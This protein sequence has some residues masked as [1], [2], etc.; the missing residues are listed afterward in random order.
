[1]NMSLKQ[2]IQNKEVTIGSWITIGDASVAEIMLKADFDWLTIDME[3]SAITLAEAQQLIRVIDL[4]GKTPLVR[5]S[6]NDPNVIKRVMDAGAHGVIV[7]MVNSKEEALAAVNAVQ[8]PP[9]GMRGVGLGRAQGYGVDFE[10]YQKWV[11]SES[12][13]IIQVEHIRAVESLET[14]LSVKGVDGFMVGPYDLSAS[15]GVPGEFNHPEMIKALE[16]IKTVS[17]KFNVASGIHVI[18]PEPE[19]VLTKI[20]EG[21]KFI[22][23]SLDSLFLAETCRRNLGSV[24]KH[25]TQ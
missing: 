16:R 23:F 20:K 2:K 4:G 15:L 22:A 10:K 14:I 5:V 7:P 3:H 6:H 12:V 1:M 24:R 8:Y 21:F 11:R 19:L 17:Q 25:I 13:V 18:Q 9:Q